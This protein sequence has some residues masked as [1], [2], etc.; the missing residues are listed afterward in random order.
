MLTYYIALESVSQQQFC[1]ENTKYSLSHITRSLFG[2]CFAQ[3]QFFWANIW[4]FLPPIHNNVKKT[5]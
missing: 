4:H 1:Q 5:N 3:T 2:T